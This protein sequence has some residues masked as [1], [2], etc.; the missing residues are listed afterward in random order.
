[1]QTVS[2]YIPP[3]FSH[4]HHHSN[5]VTIH[6]P[7]NLALLQ[8]FF[9][10]TALSKITAHDTFEAPLNITLPDFKLFEHNFSTLIARDKQESLNLKKMAEAAKRNQEIFTSLAEPILAIPSDSNSLF[11]PSVIISIISLSSTVLCTIGLI[12][13]G[14]KY[15]Q[16]TAMVLSAAMPNT[17]TSATLPSF[18]YTSPPPPMV[19]DEVNNFDFEKLLNTPAYMFLLLTFLVFLYKCVKLCLTKY[20]KSSLILELTDGKCSVQLPC[21]YLPPCVQ[22]C[23]FSGDLLKLTAQL[24]ISLIST[25]TVSYGNLSVYNTLTRQALSPMTTLKI[26]P[27]ANTFPALHT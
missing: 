6:H 18:H 3:R 12:Y 10:A 5:P 4:C 22:H 7:V 8:Q 24:K 19:K 11:T 26:E 20:H 21:M 27:S 16:L 14:L 13:L 2:A 17:V 15:R 1:V 25:L 9:N 23:T